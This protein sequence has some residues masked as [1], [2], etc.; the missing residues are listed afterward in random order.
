MLRSSRSRLSTW[1]AQWVVLC[2]VFGLMISCQLALAAENAEADQH[3]DHHHNMATA[4]FKRSVVE[5]VLP[6]VMLMR[7]NRSRAS[8]A[9]EINDGRP[10]VL[11]FIYTTC[12]AVCPMVSQTFAAF[13]DKLG[14]E[15][16]GVHMVSISIDPEQDTPERLAAYQK[17]YQA[18]AQWNFYTGTLEDSIKIQKAF[19]TYFGD[20]MNHRPIFF[21]RAAPGQPWVRLEAFTTPDDL[22]AEYRA[23]NSEGHHHAH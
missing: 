17:R 13:Q 20:K 6:E 3:G 23:L 7:T 8:F 5:Y 15:A 18:G 12:T 2:C 1:R 4:E 22:F 10:V 14:P 16:A 19:D 21:L 11:N 9:Q